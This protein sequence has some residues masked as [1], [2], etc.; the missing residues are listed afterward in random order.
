MRGDLCQPEPCFPPS[1]FNSRLYTRGDIDFNTHLP[2]KRY[3]NSHLYI[4]GSGSRFA[5]NKSYTEFQFTPLHERQH[6]EAGRNL[7]PYDIS[8]HA[9]AWEATNLIGTRLPFAI[10]QFTPLHER[11]RFNYFNSSWFLISIL[12]SAWEATRNLFV[13]IWS[14]ALFQ[15][16]P[17]HERR[18]GATPAKDTAWNFNSR[19]CMRGDAS[20]AR[21]EN[22]WRDFNSRLCM[23]GDTKDSGRFWREVNFNSRLCMRGDGKADKLCYWLEISILASA[24]EATR[25]AGICGAALYFNSRLCMRGDFPYTDFH[26]L[27][28]IS[29]L[30]SAWEATESRD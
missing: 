2:C 20:F 5:L 1:N 14:V 9:S 11:R 24:W 4:R 21:V 27:N 25:E 3:F 15:F 8:I 28:L 13:S 7:S 12:A 26:N 22:V 17:L 6:T 18:P 16:S 19:L 30:A 29:I 23:R 10:F